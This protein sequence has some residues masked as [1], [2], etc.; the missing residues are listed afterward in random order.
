MSD[1]SSSSSSSSSSDE[2]KK[3]EVYSNFP[4]LDDRHYKKPYE[5]Q[6]DA[7]FAAL[8]YL[9]N[10]G[11]EMKII[12]P[13]KNNAENSIPSL[14]E[15]N[16]KPKLDPALFS[17]ENTEGV[18]DD[19][20]NSAKNLNQVHVYGAASQF[21]CCE[22]TSRYTP[23]PGKAYKMYQW[24]PTQG[25]RAQ[26]Q[27]KREQVEE[28][29]ISAN[30][31]FNGL[32]HLL[33]EN[34]KESVMHGYFTPRSSAK[35]EALIKQLKENGHKIQ[36]ISTATVPEAPRWKS[37]SKAKWNTERVPN[38]EVVHMCLV[39]APA[40]GGY[41]R[42]KD[43][44]GEEVTTV[45]AGDIQYLCSLRAMQAQLQY[46]LDVRETTPLE[47]EIIFKATAPGLGVFGNHPRTVGAGFYVAMK[48]FE[49]R[50][51][52]ANIKVRV[53][54]YKSRGGARKLSEIC[55]LEEFRED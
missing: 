45:Q 39:A 18:T 52:S 9:K 38:T 54:V 24:D 32:I 7:H 41:A 1:S 27:F 30:I 13:P 21:N 29:N 8:D 3:T 2:S 46:C 42:N 48:Q 26:I 6:L 53:Q 40:F 43:E 15:V 23:P 17:W 5:E 12:S 28:L 44:D 19:I 33:D 25:P 47:K 10:V 49:D 50:L 22:A 16:F 35:A 34:T 51:R 11:F 20:Q 14:N 37:K 55:G 36:Y 4:E 31:G